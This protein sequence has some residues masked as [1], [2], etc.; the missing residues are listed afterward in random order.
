MR[1]EMKRKAE[2]MLHVSTPLIALCMRLGMKRKA[3]DALLIPSVV[4]FPTDMKRRDR[5]EVLNRKCLV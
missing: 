1:L 4:N 3:D 5:G 2:D